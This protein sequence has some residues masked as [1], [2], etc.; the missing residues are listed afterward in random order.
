M[1]KSDQSKII[2]SENSPEI[3]KVEIS[4]AEIN[5]PKVNH[6]VANRSLSQEIKSPKSYLKE[7]NPKA[8]NLNKSNSSET[9]LNETQFYEPN[10]SETQSYEPNSNQLE[11]ELTQDFWQTKG[12][13][14]LTVLAEYRPH[15]RSFSAGFFV[16][17]GSRDEPSGLEGAAHFLE[18][19]MFK[20]NAK[21]DALELNRRFDAL[22]ADYNAFTDHEMTAYHAVVLA[23]QAEGLLEL[24]FELMQPQLDPSEVEL[25]RQVILEEIEMYDDSPDSRLFDALRA[26]YYGDHPLAHPILGTRHSVAN[27]TLQ[28]LEQHR[29]THYSPDQQVLVLCGNFDKTQILA[30][31]ERLIGPLLEETHTHQNSLF[32]EFPS[33]V[34]AL[35][36]S[37]PLALN[38]HDARLKRMHLGLM[39]PAPLLTDPLSGA[40]QVL[41]EILGGDTGRFYWALMD[42]GLVDE[43]AFTCSES[44]LESH[45]EAYLSCDPSKVTQ[46]WNIFQQV[47][48]DLTGSLE[49]SELER[50]KRKLTLNLALSEETAYGRLFNLGAD[51]VQR[52]IRVTLQDHQNRI[53]SVTLE[54][55]SQLLERFPLVPVALASLG[56]LKNWNWGN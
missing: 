47:L 5:Q 25:E 23:D 8:L 32:D 9:N 39:L 10:S 37:R 28:Q 56:P 43:V 4:K 51:Y 29:K 42:T 1:S 20:G 33:S 14:G 52:G 35:S 44:P 24:L 41:A 13:N 2:K 27:L 38:L 49:P 15:S 7:S 17:T 16:N 21:M 11:V 6:L 40:A 34:P 45:Y 19:L 54:Q 48:Q 3:S 55:I 30:Y 36:L 18:H 53:R 22:G 50:V 46:V 12:P 26:H 31:L